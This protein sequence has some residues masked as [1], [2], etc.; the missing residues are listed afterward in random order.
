M[1]ARLGLCAGILFASIL[2]LGLVRADDRVVFNRDIRPILSDNCYKC[3]GPD[4]KERQAG[5]RLDVQGVATGKLESGST[6]VVPGKSAESALVARITSPDPDQRMPPTTTGKHLTAR[7]IDLFRRWIDQGAA[8]QGHWSFIAPKRPELPAVKDAAWERNPI[9]RFILARLEAEGLKPMPPADKVTLV[10]RVTSDLTGLPPMPA[11]VDAFLADDSPE[12]YESLVD[13]LLRSPRYGEQMARYWLDLARYGDTHGLHLD[14]ERY[15]WKYREWV[16][17][18]FNNNKPFDQFT[19]E[20]LAGDLLPNATLDQRIATGFVRCNVSTSEGGSI[21]EEVR[22]RYVVDRTE[23]MATVFLGLTLGCAVCHDHKFDPVTQ[24]EFYSLYAF[25]NSA[26][27]PAMDGNIAAT[28]P[29]ARVPSADD[30]AKLKALDEQIA[31][32][33]QKI[34]DALAKVEYTEPEPTA[35]VAAAEPKEH[36]WIDDAAPPSAQLQGNSPWEFVGKPEH[37]VFCGEKATRRQAQGL[38]Q[39]FFTGAAPG[40][41]IGEGDKLFAYV[42]LD[43]KNPPKEIM[44][45]FN[46]G[47]WEHRAYWGEDVIP[48]GNGGSPSRLPLGALPKA[49][50]WVRLEVEAAKLGLAPGAVLNGWAFTQHDGTVYWDKAGVVTR[51]P[52][53]GQGF[54]SLVAWEAYEKA[55]TKSTAPQNVR[56][57]INVEPAKRSDEHKKA[58]RDY[59]LERVY[60]T[61]RPV[62]DPLHKEIETLTKQRAD[63][64]AAIPVTLVMGDVPSPRETFVLIRGAYDKPGDKVTAGVPAA[65]PPLPKD[66]PL[67]RLGMAQWLVDPSHPLTARVTVNRFWQQF[68]GRGIV[69]TSEDFGAQGQWPTHPELLD[70]LAREF[71]ESGWNVKRLL[72]LIV[73]SA[74]YRQS[75]RVTPE[76]FERDP[77]NAL[78]ARGPRFRM[79]A[80]MV[81]DAALFTS[82]LL[83][84]KIG[85]KSVKPY[86]PAGIWEAVGFV[87]SNTR[88]FKREDGESLYRRSMYTFWKR[89]AP[90]PS[91]MAF[92]APSRE[93]CVARRARTNTPLQALVLM[94]D[95]QYVEASRHMARRMML[96][97]GSSPAQRLTYGFRLATARRPEPMELDVLNKVFADQLAHYQ[98]HKEEA[99]KL[100]SVGESKIADPLDPAEHAAYTMLANLILNLDEAVTKE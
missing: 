2:S 37:P 76:L 88:D 49:G 25:Y 60:A 29:V 80:E 72:K 71:V 34:V 36:V 86:Q 22:V 17:G 16:I 85:G 6:A 65:F 45:Q 42:Y 19:V 13:R 93:N 62:F 59:F 63:A 81:R 66:A 43:P 56:D 75:S 23:T 10:R 90:P 89:T 27:D 3:H 70:W 84:E 91:L 87:G 68:F 40:L 24:K 9:D 30:E 99:A 33:R 35:S 26:A 39:H 58:I 73:T 94:N 44:L 98:G 54:E 4:E 5:L 64:D 7:Q 67:N 57:A 46:D 100:L 53:D 96:E 41:K 97:G 61:T 8:W 11:E 77:E 95:E 83:V 1:C 20:Q 15:M 21:D 52:Q 78:V 47:A 14:N 79:D 51:T 32:A 31:A 18:A 38:S 12:A 48:W 74:A 50:E 92:D 82:G 28:P 55:Q 69:K